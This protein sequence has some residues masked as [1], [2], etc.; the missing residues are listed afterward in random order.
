MSGYKRTHTVPFNGRELSDYLVKKH[1]A[2]HI[3]TTG[4]HFH[5][6]LPNGREVGSVKATQLVTAR[7]ARQ[8]AEILGMSYRDLRA[9]IGHPIIETGAIKHKPVKKVEKRAVTKPQVLR[10]IANIR[11]DL[12]DAQRSLAGDRDPSVYERVFN[13]LQPAA[14]CATRARDAITKRGAA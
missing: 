7:H 8:V 3:R 11:A 9:D 14:T 4:S 13:A 6:R 10:L 12:D 5:F 2:V 1:G